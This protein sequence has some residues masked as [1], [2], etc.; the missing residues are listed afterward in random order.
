MDFKLGG[1]RIEVYV[2]DHE[3]ITQTFGERS[4]KTS[5]LSDLV[6]LTLLSEVPSEIEQI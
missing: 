4:L 5:G 1:T 6:N 2:G 3:T